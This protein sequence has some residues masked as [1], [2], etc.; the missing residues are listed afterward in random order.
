VD[1]DH[2]ITDMIQ[3]QLWLT[4]YEAHSTND[5]TRVIELLKDN[6]C[7]LVL[8]DIDMPPPNGLTLLRE[9]RK[10]YPFLAIVMLTGL[11]DAET[12]A[13]TMREGATDYIVKS[14]PQAQ[15]VSRIERALEYSQLLRERAIAQQTLERRVDEQT[16]QLRAQSRQ[17]S[18]M[19]DRLSLTYQATVKALE[20]ALDIGD[21]SAPGHCRRVAKLSVRLATQ[22]RI[23]GHDLVALEYG[24]LLHDIGKLGIP[25]TILMKP[26]PLTPEEWTTMRRHPEI[27]C[28]IVGN[29]D[30]LEDALPI[31]RHHHEHYDGNGYPDALPGDEIPILARIFAV[32]DSF[33]AQT[34]W[35]PYKD[36]FDADT[37]LQNIQADRGVMYDPAIVDAFTDMVREQQQRTSPYPMPPSG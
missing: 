4:G 26:G 10:R 29:I 35:R 2:L 25:D 12:A 36:T 30:F 15:L 24:A 31:I 11:D 17:L 23:K 34:N 22:L 13:H 18:Q 1:D 7:D 21:Q 28:E 20:A 16:H 37:A 5:S 14:S 33:D 8:L 27:G 19:L 9:I 3:E 6:G 32:I